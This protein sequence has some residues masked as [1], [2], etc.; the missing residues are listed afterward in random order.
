MELTTSPG[1]RAGSLDDL[2]ELLADIAVE[3]VGERSSGSDH[4]HAQRPLKML[5]AEDTEGGEVT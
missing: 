5:H 3:A 2:L 1:A 4:G